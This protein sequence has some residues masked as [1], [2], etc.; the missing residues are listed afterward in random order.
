M[1]ARDPVSQARMQRLSAALMAV[2]VVGWVAVAAITGVVLFYF[3]AVLGLAGCSAL[4]G[5]GSSA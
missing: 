1:S 4:P 3:A 2:A 5:R